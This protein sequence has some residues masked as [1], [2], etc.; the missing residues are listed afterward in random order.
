MR[1]DYRFRAVILGPGSGSLEALFLKK[2]IEFSVVEDPDRFCRRLCDC[3]PEDAWGG[4]RCP[5]CSGPEEPIAFG[6]CD[7]IGTDQFLD[8]FGDPDLI[9]APS[10]HTQEDIE[11]CLRILAELHPRWAFLKWTPAERRGPAP[12]YRALG[13][14]MQKL[15]DFAYKAEWQATP[16]CI[17]GIAWCDRTFKAPD[18]PFPKLLAGRQE[19]DCRWLDRLLRADHDWAVLS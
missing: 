2:G 1:E 11:H 18:H 13:S 8:E 7:C 10:L 9:A 17:L 6:D 15:H 4:V 19:N 14:M 5:R 16:E 12:A 3:D